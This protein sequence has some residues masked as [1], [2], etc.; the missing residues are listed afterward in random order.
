MTRTTRRDL[1]TTGALGGA[2][3]LAAPALARA[4]TIKW[5]MVTS[6]PKNLPGP[7]VTAQHLAER[8]G[9]VSGGAIEIELYA[10]NELVSGLEVLDAVAGGVAHMGH[11]AAFFWTGKMPAAAYFTAVPFGLTPLEHIAWIEHGG[12]QALWDE[13]YGAF[14]VKPFMAG[15]SGMQMGAWSK[16]EITGLADLRGLKFRI[17]GLG[18]EMMEKLGVVPVMTAPTDILQ[19]LQTGVIDATEFLGPFS[20]RAAGFYKVAPWYY[21]PGLH[22]PNG[23]GECIINLEAWTGLS[24]ELRA[25]VEAA[26]RAENIVAL[27][28]TEWQNAEALQDLVSNR[29]VTVQQWPQDIITAAREAAAEVVAQFAQGSDI[30]QRIHASYEEMRARALH[31]SRISAQA[32]LEAR[33]G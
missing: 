7:G 3:A 14:H 24:P 6:W 8:I 1:L 4:E 32:F 9:Q 2:A 33:N 26:C 21:G 27:A 20:D 15:N 29:G 16:K 31:W 25:I 5:R 11:T 12:G 28:E 13:L 10:A 22:E 18:G 30:E 23:T 19:S 17:P